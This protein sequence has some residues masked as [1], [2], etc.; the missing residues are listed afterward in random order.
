MLCQIDGF[1]GHDTRAVTCGIA[2]SQQIYTGMLTTWFTDHTFAQKKVT[3]EQPM[4]DGVMAAWG[5]TA[6]LV[7]GYKDIARVEFLNDGGAAIWE[8]TKA[9]QDVLAGT[10]NYPK[11]DTYPP[12]VLIAELLCK[13]SEFLVDPKVQNTIPPT[14]V[15][16]CGLAG[17][18]PRY[19]G[20]IAIWWH[21]FESRIA[22]KDT[23]PP[24]PKE[25]STLTNAQRVQH[26]TVE[27][28]VIGAAFAHWGVAAFGIQS[29]ERRVFDRMNFYLDSEEQTWTAETVP[30]KYSQP[31]VCRVLPFLCRHRKAYIHR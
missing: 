11:A 8:Q 3:V 26:V 16:T 10:Y 5:I 7:Y 17:S 22:E 31:G 21:T 25:L 30:Q 28:D 4:A 2:G 20:N 13:A 9:A 24:V 29:S 15:V 14:Y 18:Q 1:L 23:P 27:H 6:M 12:P 19:S